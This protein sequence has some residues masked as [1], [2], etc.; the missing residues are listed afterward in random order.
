MDF[1]PVLPKTLKRNNIIWVIVDRLTKSTHFLPIQEG[2]SVG[3]L[4]EL[5]SVRDYRATRHTCIYSIRQ[6]FSLYFAILERISECIGH[7]T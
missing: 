2:C 3:K 7:Q 4:S 5:F 6:R 1:V